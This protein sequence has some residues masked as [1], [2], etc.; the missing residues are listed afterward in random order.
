V[1]VGDELKSQN[2]SYL[3]VGCLTYVILETLWFYL[4]EQISSV[5]TTHLVHEQISRRNSTTFSRVIDASVINDIDPDPPVYNTVSL[6]NEIVSTVHEDR[7]DAV[8]RMSGAWR[9]CALAG[10]RDK[11]RPS[12]VDGGSEVRLFR[13]TAVGRALVVGLLGRGR[14]STWKRVRRRRPGAPLPFF[15]PSSTGTRW[16]SISKT[17]FV[18]N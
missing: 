4:H 2:A 7:S 16:K 10:G 14:K 3:G 11:F 8:T 5:R 15:V 13:V 9:V 18:A 12:V 17:F 1:S 6:K